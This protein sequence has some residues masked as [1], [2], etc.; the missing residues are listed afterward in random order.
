[1]SRTRERARA[2]VQEK[3]TA[4]AE[5]HAT[6]Q[7][8]VNRCDFVDKS[9]APYGHR[10]SMLSTGTLVALG[11]P[12]QTSADQ[13]TT[14]INDSLPPFTPPFQANVVLRPDYDSDTT[15]FFARRRLRTCA[16]CPKTLCPKARKQLSP[17]GQ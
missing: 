4:N 14:L 13:A 7:Q 17:E 9:V 5:L 2:R 6:R 10:S 1:M 15:N 12:P 16:L 3:A 11:C 8:R